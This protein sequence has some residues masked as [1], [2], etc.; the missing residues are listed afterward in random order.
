MSHNTDA[1]GEA[2]AEA[3]AEAAIDEHLA[4]DAI[5][6]ERYRVV[7]QLATGG[8]SLIYRGLDER[9]SRPVCIKVF[10]RRADADGGVHQTSYEHFVQEAFALS[11]LTHP[12]TLR[13]YDF[14]HLGS[15]ATGPPFQVSEFMNGGTLSERVRADGPLDTRKA[16]AMLDGLCG[17]LAEAHERG[18]THRDIKPQNVLFLD[19]GSRRTVKL[20]DFGIAKYSPSGDDDL[21]YQAGDTNVIAGRSLFLLSRSWAAPEQLTGDPVGPWSDIYSMAL[22]A[23]YMTT[24]RALFGTRDADA[25]YDLRVESDRRIEDALSSCDVPGPFIA[26]IKRACHLDSAHRP[27]SIDDL[28]RGFREALGSSESARVRLLP[29]PSPPEEAPPTRTRD[30]ARVSFA[31]PPPM[32][33]DRRLGFVPATDGVAAIQASRARLELGLMRRGDG[34]LVHIKGLSCFVAIAGRR[35]SSAVQIDES[36][37][38]D[39]VLPNQQPIAR[40]RVCFGRSTAGHLVFELGDLDVAV[41]S[42]ECGHAVA[43]DFGPGAECFFVYESTGAKR[44]VVSDANAGQRRRWRQ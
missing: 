3:A 28:A 11:K 25:A 43:L 41:S 37:F 9:L 27:A 5:L 7:E 12:N 19:S 22:I 2:A 20:A 34:L 30:R 4:V 24:G 32:I 26:L 31:N 35:A 1:A 16:A 44:P 14:G 33:G 21:H 36:D 29:L 13:I 38:I 18:I 39:F 8:H 40:A 17:A 15:T 10:K 42:E 23:A 6:L